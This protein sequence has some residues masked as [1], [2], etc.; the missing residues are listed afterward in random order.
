MHPVTRFVC[1]LRRFSLAALAIVAAISPELRIALVASVV[2]TILV[3]STAQ[4]VPI[5]A[6]SAGPTKQQGDTCT[7]FTFTPSNLPSFLPQS[8]TFTCQNREGNTTAQASASF[9][10]V[11]VLAQAFSKAGV[12]LGSESAEGAFAEATYS[13][14]SGIFFFTNQTGPPVGGNVPVK[15]NLN[16][17]VNV[18][19]T[20]VAAGNVV[21]FGI[22][23]GQ[24]V[25][26][27]IASNNVNQ[28]CS[29]DTVMVPI[30]SQI[31]I[32]LILDAIAFANASGQLTSQAGFADAS[33]TFSFPVGSPVFDLPAGVTFNDPDAF[34]FNNIYSPPGAPAPATVPEPPT[35]A[36]FG[37]GLLMF[38]SC[39]LMR[40]I[41]PR[42]KHRQQLRASA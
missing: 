32:G 21:G 39:G 42:P 31:S 17:S 20:D 36:L 28:G 13:D 25:A 11:K 24:T 5:M 40:K 9:G 4:S 38:W 29:V 1:A 33:H 26:T 14:S 3:P 30:S 37:F 10:S 2:A 15:L 16:F 23:N 7:N 19:N 18:N 27:C 34:I 6:A 35:L 41:P 22:V 8:A 12:N